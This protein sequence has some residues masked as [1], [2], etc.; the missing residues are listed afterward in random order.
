M[1]KIIALVIMIATLATMLAACDSF[2]CDG[3]LKE[4]TGKKYSVEI[5]GKQ[6]TVCSECKE[7]FQG[8]EALTTI[9][10][11]DYISIK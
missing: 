6:C 5:A 4:T 3:C 10:P 8:L 2:T 9:N 7:Y 11:Q 1:K